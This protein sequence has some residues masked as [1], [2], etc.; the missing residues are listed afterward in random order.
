VRDRGFRQKL[1]SRNRPGDAKGD[2][3]IVYTERGLSA[4]HQRS[5]RSAKHA[6]SPDFTNSATVTEK[7][8]SSPDKEKER[9]FEKERGRG[10]S[11]IHSVSDRRRFW[12]K[13]ALILCTKLFLSRQAAQES[14]KRRE[15]ARRLDAALLI[16][17]VCQ[18]FKGRR[19]A[20]MQMRILVGHRGAVKKLRLAVSA[21]S[22]G[23]RNLK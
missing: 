3:Q 10:G 2:R 7:D 13:S 9:L 12:Y 5:A 15:A 14:I 18:R 16:I 22:G 19:Y 4:S 21:K 17:R 8:T 11:E 20:A 1:P 23:E 6:L